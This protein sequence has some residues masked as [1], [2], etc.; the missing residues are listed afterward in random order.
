M[1]KILIALLLAGATPAMAGT[2][3]P[4][5]ANYPAPSC[6]KPTA[7]PDL[8]TDKPP[9]NLMAH[10]YNKLVEG[11]NTALHDYT[12]CMNDYV[13]NAQTDINAIRDKVNKAVADGK[14]P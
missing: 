2:N 14:L 12:G 11:Y 10:N 8:P 5:I 3:D 9:T 6:I 7:V 1:K 4:A 13:A